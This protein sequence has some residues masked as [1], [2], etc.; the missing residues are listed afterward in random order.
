MLHDS[1]SEGH[2]LLDPGRQGTIGDGCV[3]QM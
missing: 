1:D 3:V 2:Q